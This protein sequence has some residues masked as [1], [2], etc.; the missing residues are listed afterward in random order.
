LVEVVPPRRKAGNK[1]TGQKRPSKKTGGMISGH[2]RAEVEEK[3]SGEKITNLENEISWLSRKAE[4]LH[5]S[6]DK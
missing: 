5:G 2:Q 4:P 6:L 3:R 1:G